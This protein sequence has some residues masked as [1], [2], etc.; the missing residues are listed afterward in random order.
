MRK[1]VKLLSL[2]IIHG[3][4]LKKILKYSEELFYITE[5]KGR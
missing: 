4:K 5:R 2:D 1:L 3:D